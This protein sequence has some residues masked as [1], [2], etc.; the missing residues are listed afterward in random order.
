MKQLLWESTN[1][2]NKVP[3][4]TI[5]FWIIKILC[6]TVGE[7]F[8]DW[9]IFTTGVWLTWTTIMMSVLLCMALFFQFKTTKYK[10]SIYWL[11]VVLISVV[12]TLITDSLTDNLGVPLVVTTIV[13]TIVLVV[14]FVIWYRQEWTLSIH[15]ITTPRRELFYWWAIL[16]TFALGT[17]AGDLIAEWLGLWY[18][19]SAAIFAWVIAIVY[20]GY[21]YLSRWVVAT[22][23]I[24]YI[25]TRPLWASIGDLLSQ[26]HSDG[27]RWLGTTWTSVIFLIAIAGLT[28]YMS[29]QQDHILS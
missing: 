2:L 26:S 24:A 14:T 5:F 16:C 3:E 4:I 29:R 1:R 25:L 10:P 27:W 17:A 28:W 20:A 13:C 7:T 11:V 15:S 21:R 8:A 22:F 9:L 19:L 6:T 23:W 18:M 12:G